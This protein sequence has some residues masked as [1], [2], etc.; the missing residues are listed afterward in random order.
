MNNQSTGDKLGV[1]EVGEI[2]A[3]TPTTMKYYL[4][5]Y[6]HCKIILVRQNANNF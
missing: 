1:G 6:N 4:N 2:M 5:R 3:K